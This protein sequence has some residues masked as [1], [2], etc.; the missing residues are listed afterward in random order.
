VG[1]EVEGTLTHADAPQRPES[2]MRLLHF[3]INTHTK[4]IF[5]D[6]THAGQNRV[7]E[8]TRMTLKKPLYPQFVMRDGTLVC[9]L[10]LRWD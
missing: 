7:R 4:L 1:T 8:L 6:A 9:P 3:T 2:C 5:S 10:Y